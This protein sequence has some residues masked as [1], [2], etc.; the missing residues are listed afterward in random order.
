R[1]GRPGA[2]RWQRICGIIG[3]QILRATAKC[4]ASAR[5]KAG[6]KPDL[7]KFFNPR[8]SGHAFELLFER[9]FGHV[10][11]SLHDKCAVEIESLHDLYVVRGDSVVAEKC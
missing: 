9:L 11:G 5:R 8:E 2:G 6:F 3:W 7:L 4:E 10:F 1:C